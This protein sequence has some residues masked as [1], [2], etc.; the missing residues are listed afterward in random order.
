M[1]GWALRRER[2]VNSRGA[3]RVFDRLRSVPVIESV[4]AA[5]RETSPREVLASFPWLG[6]A[7][8]AD[9]AA[10]LFSQWAC[11]TVV[12]EHV[13]TPVLPRPVFEALHDRAGV[14]AVWPVGNAGILHVYGYLLSTTPTP[15]GLKR[16]RW[17]DGA[18]A[19]AC[20]LPADAFLPWRTAATLLERVTA[21]Q[22]CLFAAASTLTEDLRESLGDGVVGETAVGPGVGRVSA[23]GYG[24]VGSSRRYVTMFPVSDPGA[25][26]AAITAGPPRVRWNGVR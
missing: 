19:A 9:A 4:D 2:H 20:G 24:L 17:L 23:L 25:I 7:I 12:D 11:S 16:D 18:L 22:E 3:A 6:D 14:D 13:G 8:D 5:L 21:A 10:D 1:D 26:E 15:F